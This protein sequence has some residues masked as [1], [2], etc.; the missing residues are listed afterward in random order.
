MKD[1]AKIIQAKDNDRKSGAHDEYVAASKGSYMKFIFVL[2]QGYQKH[3]NT[4][5]IDDVQ[6]KIDAEIGK[7][8]SV[9]SLVHIKT[10]APIPIRYAVARSI[11]EEYRIFAVR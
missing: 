6:A 9:V 5:S 10:P 7:L 1:E 2:Y 4:P 11:G 8:I 3:H